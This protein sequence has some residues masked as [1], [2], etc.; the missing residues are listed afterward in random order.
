M[1]FFL[2]DREGRFVALNRRGREYC[3]VAT[4]AEAIGKTDFDFFPADRAASYQEEDRLVM[5][6]GQSVINRMEA[7]PETI[8]SPRL[9]VTS[10]I[11]VRDA[12]GSIVGVAG[13]S[14]RVEK[15]RDS[16]GSIAR[17]AK[18]VAHLHEN[19]GDPVSTSD[20][21]RQAGFSESQ[22]NRRFRQAF[23]TSAR[24][25]LLR[26][27]VESA[28]HML[29]ETDKTVSA[30]AVECGFYDHAHLTR[31]FHQQMRCLPTEYRAKRG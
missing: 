18:V 21:A 12:S 23:G 2:K 19:F 24:Q 14:R 31:S 4:E 17:F 30:I 1:S 26:I 10:K 8:R 7:S 9:V 15:F 3:G 25:Y 11:P 5:D 6:S 13:F 16:S 27:R 20:L 29:L 28:A 22:F